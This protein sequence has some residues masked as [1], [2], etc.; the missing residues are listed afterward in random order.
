MKKLFVWGGL[1]ILLSSCTKSIETIPFNNYSKV[2][3]INNNRAFTRYTI[4][5][6]DHFCDKNNLAYVQTDELKFR[7]R[8]NTSALYKTINPENQYD[9]NKLYG[10]SDNQA[11]HHDYSA[12]FGWR[13]SDN[14]LRLF[15]YVYNKGVRTHKEIRLVK[16]GFTYSCSIKVVGN[17]YEFDANGIK[18]TMPRL[19]TTPKAFGYK[20]YPYFGGDEVAPQ[21]ITIDLNDL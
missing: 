20:L 16:P 1:L 17:M 2:L 12:R 18:V 15:A 11:Q 4:K 21:E 5:T 19:A 8:F 14:A 3:P 9:I 10:F 6:G 13:Y 7:V